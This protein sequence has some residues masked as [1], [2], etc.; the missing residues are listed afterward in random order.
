MWAGLGKRVA[1][2]PP[3]HTHDAHL[4]RHRAAFQHLWSGTVGLHLV[5]KPR[6]ENTPE[7]GVKLRKRARRPS[8]HARAERPTYLRSFGAGARL[9]GECLLNTPL[10]SWSE[11][12]VYDE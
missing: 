2:T 9:P 3:T 11:E 6:Y 10:T 7:N 8:A 5:P 1:C 4:H 12:T